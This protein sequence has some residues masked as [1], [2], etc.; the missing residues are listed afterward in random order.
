MSQVRTSR[1]GD[2]STLGGP[3]HPIPA[4]LLGFLTG[5]FFVNIVSRLILGPLLPIVE[6]E[7]GFR[8]GVA[9]SLFFFMT[10]GYCAGL[11]LSA[12]AAWRFGHRVTIAVSSMTL[13]TALLAVSWAPS[14]SG[15]RVGLVLL[16]VGSGL[17]LPSAIAA[18][19]ENTREASWGKALAIHE[20]GP[21]FGYIGTPLLTELLL[22]FFSWRGVLGVFGALAILL[23][24]IF[25]LCGLGKT[26]PAQPPRLAIMASLIRDRAFWGMAGLFLVS[27]GVG[28]GLYTMMPLFLIHAVG[29]DRFSANMVTGLTRVSAL[30][31]VFISGFLA[32]RLGRSRAVAAS[33]A[34][35]G[36][37]ALMV[38][39]A[40]GP[41][42]SPLLIFLQA[43]CVASFYPAGYAM[44]STVFPPPLRNIAVSTVMIVAVLVGA[45]AV[46]PGVGFLAD[47]YSFSF[48]FGAAGLATLASLLL[49]GCFPSGTAPHGAIGARE[50]PGER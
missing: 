10:V 45:G 28:L 36:S 50:R 15:M 48:A 20:L 49:L 17:Y 44:L 38:A 37:C 3:A 19:T 11:Y 33:L 18:L 42:I 30:P 4:V 9:G 16:G 2:T 5:M 13:G 8:H 14:L 46:P 47:R 35:A 29:L 32:D 1:S 24:V 27:V 22:G 21:N 26:S 12:Y 6:E 7:F 23:G 41:W 34:A 43:G 39:L 25:W 40:R 31:S